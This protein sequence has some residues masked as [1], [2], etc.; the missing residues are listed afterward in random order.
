MSGDGS[1]WRADGTPAD[2][3][4]PTS[5]TGPAFTSDAWGASLDEGADP[6]NLFSAEI[7]DVDG[8]DW[9]VADL[10]GDAPAADGGATGLDFG[11]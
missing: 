7:Q 11:L 6:T 9:D 2:G 10:W 1:Q 3:P 8:A 4:E 5:A